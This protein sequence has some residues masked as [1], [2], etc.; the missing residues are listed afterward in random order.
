MGRGF[1]NHQVIVRGEETQEVMRHNSFAGQDR[2]IIPVLLGF[3]VLSV[4]A[5]AA[6][7]STR[8]L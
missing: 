4:F 5:A 3:V 6:G 7:Y 1:E 2:K 8:G